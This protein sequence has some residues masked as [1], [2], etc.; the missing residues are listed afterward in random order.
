MSG[1][2][3]LKHHLLYLLPTNLGTSILLFHPE[4]PDLAVTTD[5]T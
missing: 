4:N 2:D 5:L 1:G 3:L